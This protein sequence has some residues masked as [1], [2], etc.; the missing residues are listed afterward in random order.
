MPILQGKQLQ[1]FTRVLN[2]VDMNAGLT[3]TD[4]TIPSTAYTKICYYQVPAQ[5]QIALGAG[6]IANGVDSREYVEIRFDDTN[7]MQ[8]AGKFRIGYTN[9]N[10]TNI[11]IIKEERSDNIGTASTVKLAEV[12]NLRVGEDSYLIIYCKPDATTL[13]DMSDANN[14]VLLPVTVYQ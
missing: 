5:Q 10:E 13:L 1:G 3:A 9:A 8:I 7:G 11:Q 6:E 2:Q 12:K 4:V 14:K